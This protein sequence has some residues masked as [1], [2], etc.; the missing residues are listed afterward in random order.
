MLN[1]NKD[2]CGFFLLVHYG[3]GTTGMLYAGSI[4]FSTKQL[5]KESAV[6]TVL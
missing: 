6:I 5:Y 4:R 3:S 1:N 2:H